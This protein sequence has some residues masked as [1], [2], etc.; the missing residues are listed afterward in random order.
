[1]SIAEWARRMRNV[2][3]ASYTYKC[4]FLLE[5]EE[6]RRNKK[7]D[8]VKEKANAAGREKAYFERAEGVSVFEL[9]GDAAD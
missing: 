2:R 9:P 1:M 5:E 6:T 7:P 8:H 4:E 3:G